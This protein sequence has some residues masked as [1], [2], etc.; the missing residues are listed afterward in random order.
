VR[1]TIAS[2][3]G[4]QP[5]AS[6]WDMKSPEAKASRHASGNLTVRFQE[7]L[8]AALSQLLLA[9]D[10]RAQGAHERRARHDGAQR[11]QHKGRLLPRSDHAR[12]IA[13]GFP[14][15]PHL[16]APW[17]ARLIQQAGGPGLRLV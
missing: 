12:A 13:A 10:L 2:S 7:S 1:S 16:Q 4:L 15:H 8:K 17:K 5:A 14:G 6:G 9:P 3:L 11:P